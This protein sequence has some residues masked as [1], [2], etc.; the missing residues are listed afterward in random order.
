MLFERF[1]QGRSTK[2]SPP[3]HKIIKN[4]E[5][6]TI[7]PKAVPATKAI[8][9]RDKISAIKKGYEPNPPLVKAIAKLPTTKAVITVENATS[10]VSGNAKN[11]T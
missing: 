8:P 2:E 11:A 1:V 3:K 10:V 5:A 4:C 6:Q 7:Q 9:K